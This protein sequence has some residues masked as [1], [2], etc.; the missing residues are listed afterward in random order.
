MPRGRRIDTAPVTVPLTL[1]DAR[2]VG[3]LVAELVANRI[4]ARPGLRVLLP[5]GDTPRG[6]YAALR[7]HAA[8]GSLPTAH[9][10]VL[11][12]PRRVPR[13]AR[14]RPA[15][16][17]RGAGRRAGRDPARAPRGARRLRGRSG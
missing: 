9:V 8:D 14:R 10:A 6:M 11:A 1:A 13:P 4:R 15:E 3:L 2:P 16:R 17:P 12:W 5:T 7:A